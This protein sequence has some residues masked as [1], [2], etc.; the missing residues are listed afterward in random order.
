ME[1][2]E[3]LILLSQRYEFFRT[4]ICGREFSTLRLLRIPIV[5]I[6][7]KITFI[8][9]DLYCVAFFFHM[10]I[11]LTFMTN[12]D[13]IFAYMCAFIF[14]RHNANLID[15]IAILSQIL[16][17]VFNNKILIVLPQMGF[18]GICTGAA[19]VSLS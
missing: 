7:L 1:I 6:W 19:M 16:F 5:S 3:S 14:L 12:I 10:L 2:S 11:F 8:F 17:F 4:G 18:A 13:E 15:E 9:L